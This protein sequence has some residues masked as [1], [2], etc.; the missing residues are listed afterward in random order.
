MTKVKMSDVA[1]LAKVSK[2]TVSQYLNGRY[3]HMSEATKERIKSAIEQLNYVPNSIARSLKVDS[4]KT[5]GVV[6]RDVSGFN[7][8]KVLRGVD[9]YCKG[10][11][12]NVF[13][14]NTDF[15]AETERRAFRNLKQMRVDGIITISSGKNNELLEEFMLQGIPVVQFQLEYQSDFCNTVLSNNYQAAFE[16]TEYLIQLGHKKIAFLTQDY[17]H[18]NSRH[19]RFLGFVDALKKHQIPFTNELVINWDRE[20]GF[21]IKITELLSA[22]NA[23]TALF[24]QHLALTIDVL[25]QLKTST[26]SI[27]SD[28]SLLSFDEIPMNDYLKVPLTTI[29]QNPHQIGEQSAKLLLNKIE[30]KSR[31]IEKVVVD[32]QLVKRESCIKIG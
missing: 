13:I 26:F 10:R 11:N 3:S 30:A 20:N 5:I 8:A 21:E 18:N 25:D 27:P 2:S 14:Y 17:Q 7:T 31:E 16:G 28:V 29:E 22:H 6:V 12:Y 9:D 24:T 15:D 1:D 32:C 19:E 23:P 4:T